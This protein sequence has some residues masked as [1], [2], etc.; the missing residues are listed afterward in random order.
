MMKK[1]TST[2]VQRLGEYVMPVKVAMPQFDLFMAEGTITEWLKQ[3]GENVEEEEPVAIIETS[4]IEVEV[5][6]PASGIF[7]K[8]QPEGSTVSVG[9]T[10]ALITQQDEEVPLIQGSN[11]SPVLL[12]EKS[13]ERVTEAID[14]RVLASPLAKKFAK[15]HDINLSQI[16]GTGRDGVITKKDVLSYLEQIN[17]E[18]VE[19]ETIPLSGW[20]K[21]MADRMSYSLQTMAQ[22]TTITEADFTELITLRKKLISEGK[23]RISYTVFVVKA[24]AQALK[25][26]PLLNSSLVDGKIIVKKY[27]NI[28]VAVA[29]DQQGLIVPVIHRADEKSL[30]ELNQILRKMVEKAR[31][32]NL[33]IQDVT[34]GTFTVTNV[35][36]LG[37]TMSTPIINPPESA[38]LGV[39]AITK[40]PVVVDEEIAIRSTAYLCLSYDHRFIDGAPAIGL[41]QRIKQLLQEPKLLT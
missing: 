24:V 23:E 2:S 1:G 20:R 40:K 30:T 35:G 8:T 26:F 15:E 5:E 39:G 33:S 14:K 38:I 25:E 29:R 6:A 41:L 12:E 28:G 31:T 36:P 3:D 16:T 27:R 9:E 13:S 18:T 7:Y 17:V 21:V 19:E 37:V 22:L 11:K 10:I 34:G 32:D 4:K